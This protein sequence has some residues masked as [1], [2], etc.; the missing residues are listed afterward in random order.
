MTKD[1]KL[2]WIIVITLLIVIVCVFFVSSTLS[3]QTIAGLSMDNSPSN[4]PRLDAKAGLLLLLDAEGRIYSV[5]TNK[6]KVE[7]LSSD[8]PNA[9]HSFLAYQRKRISDTGLV[10]VKS[11]KNTPYKTQVNILDEL[12]MNGFKE[13]TL[14]QAS[15]QDETLIELYKSG[16]KKK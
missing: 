3:T 12:V 16:K 13:Y 14:V 11:Y 7:E 6:T 1:R 10:V 15:P 4:D 8:Q 5:N 9:L 2:V